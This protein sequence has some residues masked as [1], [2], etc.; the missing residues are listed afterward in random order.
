MKKDIRILIADDDQDVLY[1]TSRIV[2]S[3]GYEVLN[4]STGSECLETARRQRP[5]LILLDVMLPD[6]EGT[7]ICR[8]IK[9]DPVLRGTFVVLI[10]GKKTASDERADGLNFGADGY[11]VRPISN[12]ELLAWVNALVRILKAER[13]RDRLISELTEALAKVKTLSG[14]LPICSHCKKIRDDKGYWNHVET[15][16]RQHSEVEFSHGICPECLKKHYPDYDV[17]GD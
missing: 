14:M 15:Y 2:K 8:Q 1:A 16:I 13:E 7:E 4:A 10:S 3:G 9:A 12:R 17:Q 6:A 11:I 5:D